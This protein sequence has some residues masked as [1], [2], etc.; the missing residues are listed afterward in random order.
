MIRQLNISDKDVVFSEW[1]LDSLTETLSSSSI[2]VERIKLNSINGP[3]ASSIF[4]F[5]IRI[6]LD[7]LEASIVSNSSNQI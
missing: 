5:D 6:Y 3:S 7:S 4:L 1:L 2:F